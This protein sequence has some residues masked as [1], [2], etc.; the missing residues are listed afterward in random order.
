MERLDDNGAS[1]GWVVKEERALRM[2]VEKPKAYN[3]CIES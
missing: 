3:R 1:K 2:E